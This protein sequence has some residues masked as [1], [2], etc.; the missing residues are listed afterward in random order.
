MSWFTA[1]QTLGPIPTAVR[2]EVTNLLKVLL[3]IYITAFVVSGTLFWANC[4]SLMVRVPWVASHMGIGS[5]EMKLA[6]SSGNS[7]AFGECR[8][9]LSD[10][11][12]VA[13]IERRGDRFL[14]NSK[15]NANSIWRSSSA[16]TIWPKLPAPKPVETPLK[17]E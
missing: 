7:C 11:R 17:F 9:K 12:A 16:E 6:R 8:N 13:T 14:Q 10:P 3:S 4:S 2:P 15:R 1:A 5:L